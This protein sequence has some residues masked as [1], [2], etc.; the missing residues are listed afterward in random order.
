MSLKFDSKTYTKLGPALSRLRQS[1]PEI[2]QFDESTGVLLGKRRIVN[3]VKGPSGEYREAVFGP[4][5]PVAAEL[6]KELAE[7]SLADEG[8]SDEATTERLVELLK[9]Q[10]TERPAKAQISDFDFKR[11]LIPFKRDGKSV[12]LASEANVKL[13][14][15]VLKITPRLARS[16]SLALRYRL[17]LKLSETLDLFVPFAMFERC[18]SDL[19]LG[20]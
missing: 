18:L 15:N 7:K 11:R 8:V 19:S 20:R 1:L 14:F 2:L 4:F 17:H 6:V 5:E 13:A 9:Y 16:A 12:P 3:A 10:T